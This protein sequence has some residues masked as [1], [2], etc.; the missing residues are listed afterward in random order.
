MRHKVIYTVKRTCQGQLQETHQYS[1]FIPAAI[2]F[3]LLVMKYG[4]YGTM[5]FDLTGW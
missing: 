2:K 4:M 5:R 1:F 3:I